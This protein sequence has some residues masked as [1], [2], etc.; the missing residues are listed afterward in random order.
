MNLLKKPRKAVTLLIAIFLKYIKNTLF[1]FQLLK[2]KFYLM[3]KKAEY[4][5]SIFI[6]IRGCGTEEYVNNNNIVN[7][8][9]GVGTILPIFQ[10]LL[11]EKKY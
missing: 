7:I 9:R 2:F 8:K 3:K 6:I 11:N 10:I 5:E 4:A 1:K